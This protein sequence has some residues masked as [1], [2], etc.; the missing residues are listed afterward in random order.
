MATRR[1]NLL[2]TPVN[3]EFPGS[4]LRPMSRAFL[5]GYMM[6]PVVTGEPYIP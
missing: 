5:E 2:A 4:T 6:K 1:E 3:S